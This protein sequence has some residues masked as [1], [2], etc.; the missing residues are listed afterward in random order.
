MENEDLLTPA[1]I[2]KRAF[3][4]IVD[5]ILAFVIGTLLNSFVTG[6]YMFDALNGNKLQQE[7][8]SFAQDSGLCHAT[9]DESGKIKTISLF[10]Y[11]EDG[12]E[13]SSLGYLPTP[14]GALGYE[15]YLDKVWNYY[16]VFYP[17][18]TRMV[19][20]EN[21]TYS[22]DSLDSY[23]EYTYTKIFL[24]PE[25]ETVEG[26]KDV[27]LYSNDDSQPYFQYAVKEDGTANLA[28]KPILRKEI[29]DKVDAKDSETLKK[30]R[31]YFLT[32][33]E[34]NGTL[35]IS[36]G[37]YYEA[38]L[39][40]EGQKGSNQTYFTDHYRDVQI[41]SWECS[42]TALLPVYFVFFYLIPVCDKKGRAL[43]KFIFRLGVVREDDIYMN[44]LQRCLRPLFMLVLVSLTLIPNSGAS[45]IAFGAAALLDFAFLA[46]SKTG[47]GTIHDR[48][49]KT[50]VVS[51]KGSEI[52][53]NY[54]EKEIYLAKYQTQENPSSDEEMLKEDT[55]LDLS[56]INKRRDEARNITS[57][58]EFE[59]MKDEEHAKKE[60]MDPSN[61]VNL[62]KEE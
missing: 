8:Y 60:A 56:T 59:K 15:A 1:P 14:T 33:N 36:G 35:S 53:A 55:I 62:N 26:K 52:F 38:A 6:T 9:M 10:G 20:P 17:T 30:L 46:F 49:F 19:H 5:F 51:L 2:S 27:A 48:L 54:E 31:D 40:L 45:M 4:F 34:T 3:A 44:P 21:Y 47:K 61:K 24:L 37:V 42:L 32:I 58:D 12:K 11:A 18:D 29:Q 25:T 28:A 50:A 23:K 39:H 41:I 57:F 22:A 43:G 16:T 13:N 7:Y